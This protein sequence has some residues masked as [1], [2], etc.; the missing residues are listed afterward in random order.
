VVTAREGWEG[1]DDYAPFYDWE[2]ARTFGRRDIA[3]WCQCV[4]GERGPVLELGSG[5]G[6]LTLPAGRTGVG[7]VGID[8][9]AAM[10]EHARRRATRVPRRGRPA[11]VR[12][13]IRALPFKRACFGAVLAP[14]GLLQ[15]L[16]DDR[17][18]D[19]ALAEAARVVRRGGLLA[20]DL[21]PE[22]AT[23]AEHGPRE[24]LRGS[25]H[26][27]AVTLI[28]SVRQDRRRQLTIFDELFIE[29]RGQRERKRK[30]SLTFRTRPMTDMR[31]RLEHTG[32]E[33][34]SV[35]GDYDGG[36]WDERAEVWLILARRVT[37]V[38]ARK[39]SVRAPQ[40]GRAEGG[41]LRV[42]GASASLA[43]VSAEAGTPRAAR[44]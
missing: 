14:Y 43:G 8:R 12:G 39:A 44:K 33:V 3:F 35:C 4:S 23:W 17:D 18:L 1:W 2:N 24:C 7:I 6:R 40:R 10:L 32:F 26:G 21:V 38:R 42:E 13:D 37:N 22:L 15:S 9:S 25:R 20:I 41:R 28:E 36:S 11:F 27:V 5:T 30:F 34:Q 29:R 31:T 16:L 19:R